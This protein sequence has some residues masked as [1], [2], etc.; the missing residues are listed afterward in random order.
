MHI[1]NK[2]KSAAS[3]LRHTFLLPCIASRVTRFMAEI[4]LHSHKGRSH[5]PQPT[6][7]DDN[8]VI[9]QGR[10]FLISV[11][12]AQTKTSGLG[13][14]LKSSSWLLNPVERSGLW[15]SSSMISHDYTLR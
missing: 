1:T 6:Q 10:T 14:Q 5:R 7:E 12:T 2:R 15:T 9:A 4:P 13:M 3:L 11:R 8:E